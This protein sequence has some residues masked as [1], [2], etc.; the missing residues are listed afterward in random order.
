MLVFATVLIA[1]AALAI[2]SVRIIACM[3]MCSRRIPPFFATI[4]SRS[5]DSDGGRGREA[6]LDVAGDVVG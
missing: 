5:G 3:L 1:Y 6:L 4:A 2:P